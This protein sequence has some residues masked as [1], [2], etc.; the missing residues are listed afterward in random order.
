MH[1]IEL[2]STSTTA[3][4]KPRVSDSVRARARQPLQG[5]DTNGDAVLMRLRLAQA[6]KAELRFDEHG[7]QPDV[8]R[9]PNEIGKRSGIGL[10]SPARLP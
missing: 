3:F 6:D 8:G 7:I 10:G 9:A 4:M 2:L 1:R 5:R